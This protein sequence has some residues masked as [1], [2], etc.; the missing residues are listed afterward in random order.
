MLKRRAAPYTFALLVAIVLSLL[1]PAIFADLIIPF[2]N[3]NNWDG[4]GE[5]RGR[6]R[7]TGSNLPPVLKAEMKVFRTLAAPPGWIREKVTGYPTVYAAQFREH[8]IIYETAGMPPFAFAISHLEWAIP[9][10]FTLIV[11][12]YES[13]AVVRSRSTRRRNC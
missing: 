6:P 2:D 10:W 4:A 12:V 11:V 5:S 9:V 1:P 8:G 13:I 3:W 7:F